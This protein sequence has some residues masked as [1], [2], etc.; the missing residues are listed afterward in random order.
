MA[1]ARPVQ[2][3]VTTT[4]QA[5]GWGQES[6][7]PVTQKG[8]PEGNRAGPQ[9][10]C[11]RGARAG[12]VRAEQAREARDQNPSRVGKEQGRG[13]ILPQSQRRGHGL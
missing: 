4:S 2:D 7:G 11:G 6:G 5:R 8:E 13:Q 9:R 1:G 10:G 12:Q 3:T